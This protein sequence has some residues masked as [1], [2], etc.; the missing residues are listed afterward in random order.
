M[1]NPVLRA[2]IPYPEFRMLYDSGMRISFSNLRDSIT[3]SVRDVRN[4]F[5]KTGADAL[6]IKLDT[7]KNNGGWYK[8]KAVELAQAIYD[9]HKGVPEQFKGAWRSIEFELIFNNADIIN[10]FIFEAR[11]LGLSSKTTIKSDGSLRKN[12][13]DA[14]GV[15]REVVFT[16]RAGEEQKVR[17]FCHILKGKA[18]VNKTCGTHVHFDM[19]HLKEAEAEVLGKRLARCVPALRLILPKK[20]RENAHCIGTI[21]KMDSNSNRYAFVNLAAY[22]KHKTIEVRAHSGTL[23]ASK[24]LNWIAVCEK[25]MATD[26]SNVKNDNGVLLSTLDVCTIDELLKQYDFG[27]QLKHYIV[28]RHEQFNQPK[29]ETKKRTKDVEEDE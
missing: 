4:K 28:D 18:Y 17:D 14:H 12:D 19:R 16:Y 7:F 3:K 6:A 13:D 15:P 8:A 21:N 1:L 23:N 24:I 26:V 9:Q 10:D 29:K 27:D 5:R 20:R 11:R 2:Q 22:V 25:I